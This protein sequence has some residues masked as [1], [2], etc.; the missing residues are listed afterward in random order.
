MK[1]TAINIKRR[2][3]IDMIIFKVVIF[4]RLANF[5]LYDGNLPVYAPAG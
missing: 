1:N 2:N 4:F 3:D 5:I